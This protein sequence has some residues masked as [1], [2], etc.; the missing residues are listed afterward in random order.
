MADLFQDLATIA[1]NYVVELGPSKV[2][3]PAP[4]MDETAEQFQLTV[5]RMQVFSRELPFDKFQMRTILK[6]MAIHEAVTASKSSD[7]IAALTLIGKS[8]S[9]DYFAADKVEVTH[10]TPDALRDAITNRL[11]K[12]FGSEAIEAEFTEVNRGV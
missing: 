12:L 7:R 4:L 9:V 8:A 5:A 3:A 10:K 11:E 1:D 6:N 2:S